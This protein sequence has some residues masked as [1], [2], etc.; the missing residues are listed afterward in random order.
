MS[1]KIGIVILA[2]GKGT[3]LKMDIPKP[4]APIQNK[5]LIDFVIN[6]VKGLGDITLVT[7]HQENLVR[8]HTEGVWGNLAIKYVHQKEQLGT[9]HAV[10]TYFNQ[11]KNASTYKYTI[12]ACADTPLLTEDVFKSLIS[13]L[14]GKKAVCATFTEEIPTGYGRIIRGDRGFSIVE[15]K[16]AT[17]E[18]RKITEVNSGLY[19]F[20]TAFL[21]EHIKNLDSNNKAGEFY[22]TDTFK[23]GENVEAHHFE[24]KN[25]FLGVND[26]LQLSIAERKLKARL[27]K[28][29][30]YSGVRILDL[31]HTYIYSPKVGIGSIIHPNVHIDENSVVGENVVIEPGCIIRNSTIEDGVYLKAYTYI[32]DS[33]IKKEATVGPMAQLRPGSVVGEGAKVGNFVEMKNSTIGKKVG[34][35]HLS[36]LGDAE[37]GSG[38]NIGCGFIT[39]NYDGAN[40]HKTV[41]GENSFIGSDCQMIAPV[42]IGNNAYV[43][44]GSTINKNV[45]DDA[46]AIARERQVTKEGMAKKFIKTKKK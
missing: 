42:E 28:E 35:S 23:I 36:Y 9:G 18:Q 2:A 16:D 22:L 10:Q 4:L 19:I 41:I 43:G 13:A 1:D 25:F 7:G 3:R 32:T 44:S 45:P 38:T 30:I 46:F 24:D 8:D 17:D 5:K 21:A 31:S 37:V 14:D 39:C 34:L 26:L 15:E 33:H 6:S 29:L 27:M 12:V 40:K 20:E 11:N